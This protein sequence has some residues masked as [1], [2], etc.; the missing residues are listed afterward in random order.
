MGVKFGV[1]RHG[2]MAGEDGDASYLRPPED[3]SRGTEQCRQQNIAPYQDLSPGGPFVRPRTAQEH[4]ADDEDGKSRTNWL[5]GDMQ[6]FFTEVTK[7]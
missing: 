1:L 3:F 6:Q 2:A 4:Q 7:K 5:K